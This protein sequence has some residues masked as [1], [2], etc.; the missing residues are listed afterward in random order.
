MAEGARLESVF[1]GNSNVSS[2]LTLSVKYLIIKHLIDRH[3]V[4]LTLSE[5][6]KKGSPVDVVG[7]VSPLERNSRQLGHLAVTRP[8]GLDL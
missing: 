4:R 2:N 3:A 8:C 1:R 7:G 6:G 5:S